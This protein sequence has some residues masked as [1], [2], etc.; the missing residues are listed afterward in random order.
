[1]C[2]MCDAN[3]D[4]YRDCFVFDSYDSDFC[5]SEVSC[6]VRE[7]EHL[8]ERP[9]THV[10]LSIEKRDCDGYNRTIYYS[11][12]KKDIFKLLIKDAIIYINE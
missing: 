5:H 2:I 6:C 3:C 12:P 10:L 9:E 1:M 11:V 7:S 8:E 4:A